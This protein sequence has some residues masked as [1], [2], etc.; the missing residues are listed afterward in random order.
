MK[1]EWLLLLRHLLLSTYTISCS[2]LIISSTPNFHITFYKYFRWL[3]C[4]SAEKLGFYPELKKTATC[5]FILQP[6][7][8]T[9]VGCLTYLCT[10]MSKVL[11]NN[12]LRNAKFLSAPGSPVTNQPSNHD[13]DHFITPVELKSNHPIYTTNLM[14]S[15]FPIALENPS[16]TKKW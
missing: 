11:L 2:L 3:F 7:L 15:L 12:F 9:A 16:Q 14:H 1:S 13:C 8:C 10:E 6:F 5:P 4:C